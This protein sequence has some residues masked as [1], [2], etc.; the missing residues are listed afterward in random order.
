[1]PKFKNFVIF[2]IRQNMNIKGYVARN[3]LDK[4]TIDAKT[5]ECKKWNKANPGLDPRIPPLRYHNS[6]D[7]DFSK[8]V[9]GMDEVVPGVTTTIIIVEGLFDK[10]NLEIICPELFEDKQIVVVCTWGKKISPTQ[11]QIIREKGLQKAILLY[12]PD[13]VNDSKRY[14]YELTHV[15][16]DVK[17]GYLDEKDPGDLN[18]DEFYEVLTNLKTP[19]QFNMQSLQKRTL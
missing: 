6:A 18:Y 19:Q 1:M 7:T 8:I 2:A 15:V 12:D 14:S 16:Q 11:L 5:K 17:V 4:D 3:F 10:I 13:A 9:Y